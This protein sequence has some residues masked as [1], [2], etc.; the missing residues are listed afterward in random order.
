MP[1]GGTR[2]TTETVKTTESATL[3]KDADEKT[4]KNML[5]AMKKKAGGA[6]E[7]VTAKDAN[8]VRLEE[9]RKAREKEAQQKAEQDKAKKEAAVKAK[10]AEE[11][12][13]RQEE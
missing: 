4:I 3:P 11:E 1:D 6:D 13:K 9:V 7:Q 8:K 2:I 12:R 10:Q 5:E